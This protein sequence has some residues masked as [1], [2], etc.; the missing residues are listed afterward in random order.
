MVSSDFPMVSCG[1]SVKISARPFIPARAADA[2]LVRLQL[3]DRQRHRD[4]EGLGQ[5]PPELLAEFTEFT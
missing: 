2:L 5:V 3:G 1:P 4:D